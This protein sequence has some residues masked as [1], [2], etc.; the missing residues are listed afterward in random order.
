MV[1]TRRFVLG[2]GSDAALGVVAKK[3]NAQKNSWRLEGVET[4]ASTFGRG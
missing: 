2:C 1:N 3:R 4:P